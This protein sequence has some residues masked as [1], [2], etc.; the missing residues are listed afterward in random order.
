MAY[1]V[2]IASSQTRAKVRNPWGVLGL[3]IITVGIYHAF[4]WFYVNEE[5]RDLGRARNV[6]GL[7]ER[8]GLSCLASILGAWT[9][10]IATVWTYTAGTKRAQRAQRLVGVPDTLNGW[11]MLGLA[12]FTLGIGCP[13]Y[14]QHHLN[15]VWER[16]DVVPSVSAVAEGAVA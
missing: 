7:G 2:N 16:M 12:I 9:F 13:I 1:E 11:I 15:K 5:M 6:T 3:M 14:F 10:Y 8:P 4:W